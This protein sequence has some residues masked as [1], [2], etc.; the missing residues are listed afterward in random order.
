MAIYERKRKLQERGE[1]P[2]GSPKVRCQSSVLGT[3]G[4]SVFSI[5]KYSLF[6]DHGCSLRA[7]YVS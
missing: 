5:H 1:E 4:H 3:N 2:R 7:V 6:C